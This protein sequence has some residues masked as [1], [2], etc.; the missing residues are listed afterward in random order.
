V[1][2]KNLFKNKVTVGGDGSYS[3]ISGL[4][5]LIIDEGNLVIRGVA[6]ARG[7]LFDNPAGVTSLVCDTNASASGI[8]GMLVFERGSGS[9][10]DT[11]K[12]CAKDGTGP[13][14][15]AWRTLF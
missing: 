2:T 13:N 15:Y 5:R 14:N 8:V 11:L 6:S 10:K 1:S 3:P 9:A 4:G 12:I 7:I